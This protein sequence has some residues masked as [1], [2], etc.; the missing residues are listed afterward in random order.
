MGREMKVLGNVFSLPEGQVS[1]PI[2][3]NRGVFVIQ[4]Q[5]RTNPEAAEDLANIKRTESM[6]MSQRVNS[7]VY[8]ALQKNAGVKDERAK[9]Y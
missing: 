9:Y 4:V 8:N 1:E 6:N 2:I 5:S 3:G 7:Q